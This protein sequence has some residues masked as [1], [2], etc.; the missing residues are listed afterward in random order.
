MWMAD[1]VPSHLSLALVPK[2]AI[3][4]RILCFRLGYWTILKNASYKNFF[5]FFFFCINVM[6]SNRTGNKS[7]VAQVYFEI[8]TTEVGIVVKKQNSCIDFE[9]FFFLNTLICFLSPPCNF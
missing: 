4:N 1:D 6:H 5:F 8:W 2:S 7:Q 3:M 9:I